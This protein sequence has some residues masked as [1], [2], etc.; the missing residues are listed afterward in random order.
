M[1]GS[2]GESRVKPTLFAVVTAL[3]IGRGILAIAQDSAIGMTPD[4]IKWVGSVAVLDGDPAKDGPYVLR[5][6]VPPNDVTP[7]HTHP[8]AENI[9]VISGSIGFGLS[10]VFDR[11]KGRIL[12]AGSF[13]FLPAN[14]PHF[15]WT[16]PDGAIIQAHGVGPFP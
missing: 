12:P 5:I 2:K 9:T 1:S 13:F 4:Q 15:A 14:T 8:Q 3:A 10:T 11:S 6:K 7:P 16:G